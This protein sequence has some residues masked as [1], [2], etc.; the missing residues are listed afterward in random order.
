MIVMEFP[1]DGIGATN[2]HA[3]I[4]LQS[5]RHWTGKE[6]IV[7]SSPGSLRQELF[8]SPIVVLSHGT[9]A[10]PV[11]NYGNRAALALWETDWSTFTQM[12]SRYTAEAVIRSDR[13]AFMDGVSKNGFVDGYTGIRVS[14]T[15][16]RFYIVDATVWN[17][18]DEDGRYYGQAAAFPAFR[19]C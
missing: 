7:P 8:E 2:R 10:E 15:G 11:L 16:R 12:P 14:R 18:L 1:S 5:Y 9:E 13:D 3:G 6:L 17:L 19:Y 4:I